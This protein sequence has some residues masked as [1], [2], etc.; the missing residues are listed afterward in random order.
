M[1]MEIYRWVKSRKPNKRTN[2]RKKGEESTSI[3]E[4][5]KKG[6]NSHRGR[7]TDFFH[8]ADYKQLKKP[9][10]FK[11]SLDVTFN[12]S[13]LFPYFKLL[14]QTRTHSWAQDERKEKKQTKFKL[15]LDELRFPVS[16]QSKFYIVNMSQ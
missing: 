13:F 10:H 6:K 11:S 8:F 9:F 1:K 12:V 14:F 5:E 4:L 7:T 2:Q 16:K 15:R 3:E